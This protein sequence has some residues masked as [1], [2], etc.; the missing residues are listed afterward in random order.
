MTTFT[1]TGIWTEQPGIQLD[2]ER[3][4]R[5]AELVVMDASGSERKELARYTLALENRR[6]GIA[7]A[8]LP[9]RDR[10]ALKLGRLLLEM[11]PL[12]EERDE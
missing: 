1:L 12:L 5:G 3:N 4:E 10:R 9:S 8:L 6:V 11:R 7:E 2:V